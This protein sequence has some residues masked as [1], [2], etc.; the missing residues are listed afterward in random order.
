MKTRLKYKSRYEFSKKSKVNYTHLQKE[1]NVDDVCSH[2]KINKPKIIDKR[3][4]L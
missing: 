2:D 1:I 3:K 4:M